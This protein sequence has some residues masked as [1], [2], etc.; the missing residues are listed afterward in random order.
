M[1]IRQAHEQ[2]V[3]HMR[4]ESCLDSLSLYSKANYI[5]ESSNNIPFNIQ[6][7]DM[8][9]GMDENVMHE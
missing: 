9:H 6:Q 5:F 3:L 7:C 4:R 8:D 2:H 1:N